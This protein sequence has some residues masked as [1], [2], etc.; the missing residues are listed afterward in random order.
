MLGCSGKCWG[1]MRGVRVWWEVMGVGVPVLNGIW[2]EELGNWGSWGTL[3]MAGSKKRYVM[4][5]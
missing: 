3:G 2:G 1:P 5:Q 4:V